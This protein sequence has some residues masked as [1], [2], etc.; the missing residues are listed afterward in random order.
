MEQ[1]EGQWVSNI[2]LRPKPNGEH[3]LI[4]DLTKLNRLIP[5]T[6]FKM[7]SLHTALDML[8]PNAWLGSVDLRSAHFSVS[9]APAYRKFLR[10]YWNQELYQF[11]VMPNGLA[12]APRI[13]TKLLTPIFARF[14]ELDFEC[15]QYIDDSFLIADSENECQQSLLTVCETLVELGFAIHMAGVEFRWPW[16]TAILALEKFELMRAPQQFQ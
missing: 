6:H 7:C 16:G 11:V 5:Y 12:C 10:F 1:G 4:L 14:R 2:F 3:R 15:F 8:R 9:V 13:F